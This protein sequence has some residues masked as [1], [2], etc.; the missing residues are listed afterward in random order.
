MTVPLN[1]PVRKIVDRPSLGIL[2]TINKDGSPQTSVVWLGRE[3]DDVVISSEA[4]R[5]K[6]R[7]LQRD[8]RTSLTVID[9]ADP[10]HYIELRGTATV[11]DDE[12]RRVAVLLAEKYVGPGAGD[13]Y[14]ALPPEVGRVVIRLTPHRIVG[15][16]A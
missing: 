6:V 3:G 10:D 12:D 13:E 1:D 11:T 15:N 2:A 16:L 14:L 5:L 9:P 8:A 7:N 4:G